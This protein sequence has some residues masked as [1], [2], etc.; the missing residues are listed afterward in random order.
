MP[1]DGVGTDGKITGVLG[2]TIAE[3]AKELGLQLD[4]QQM[5]FSPGLEAVKT[6]RVDTLAGCAVETPER[7]TLFNL[8]NQ[9]F[10]IPL[11]I[12]QRKSTD[13][14]TIEDLK[15]QKV[16]IIQGYAEVP[17]LQKVPWIGNDL[18]L[19]PTVD[20]I[21]TDL[22]AGR[23][24]ATILGAPTTAW[25]ITQDPKKDLKYTIMKPTPYMSASGKPNGCIFPVNLNNKTLVP[26][27]ND[28]LKKMKDDGRLLAI[29]SKYNMSDP[30][31]VTAPSGGASPSPS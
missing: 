11:E 12:T 16:G 9:F 14:N 29:T 22:L 15:G 30:A 25:V 13:F 6:G 18:K 5:E 21:Y 20:A 27:M 28:I 4:V 8:T 1:Y 19:Y 17:E 26:A 23:L 10:Y 31:F 2:D 7:K 3:I 24:N